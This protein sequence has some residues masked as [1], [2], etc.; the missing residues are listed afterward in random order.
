MSFDIETIA[1][2]A[3]ICGFWGFILF[4]ALKCVAL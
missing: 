3:G 4:V 1:M 2:F